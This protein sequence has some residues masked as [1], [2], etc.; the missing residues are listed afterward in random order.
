LARF[1][2][3]GEI[4]LSKKGYTLIE[5]IITVTILTL[6]TVPICT[7]LTQ[8][9]YSNIKS[10]E[11]IAALGLAQGKI[12]ELKALSFDEI[13]TRL[14]EQYEDAV[15]SNNYY[16]RRSVKIQIEEANLLRITVR[17]QGDN[18]VVNIVTYRGKY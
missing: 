4:S 12:E 16:F 10:K 3:K 1:L 6:I 5:I 18:G 14:G 11:M 7:L 13:R 8:S 9:V 17:I 15:E 2:R